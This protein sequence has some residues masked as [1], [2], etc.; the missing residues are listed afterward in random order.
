MD[1]HDPADDLEVQTGLVIPAAELEWSASRAG[2]PGGQAVNKLSTRVTLRW[3]VAESAV[4]DDARRARLLAKLASRLTKA[5]ELI[6]HAD[7]ERSQLDNRLEARRRLAQVVR[8]GLRVPKKRRPTKPTKGSQKRRL[9][10]K[11]QRSEK[12]KLRGRPPSD[13]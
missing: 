1:R 5:G 12:K 13:Y 3:N 11:K 4:L 10:A 2:G 7:G 9:K 6:V 8:D